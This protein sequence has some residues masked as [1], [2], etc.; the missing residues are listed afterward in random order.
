MGMEILLL[1]ALMVGLPPLI[2]VLVS[3]WREHK[4]EK[5]A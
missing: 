2:M 5:Q 3:D 1:G 4:Y